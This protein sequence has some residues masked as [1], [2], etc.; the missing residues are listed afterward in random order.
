MT[1]GEPQTLAKDFE[2]R[3]AAS[4]SSDGQSI[5]VGGRDDAGP[6]LFIVPRDGGPARRLTKSE[7]INPVC[8][9]IENLI[10]FSGSQAEAKDW[11]PRNCFPLR[12]VRSDGSSIELPQIKLLRR[13]ERVRFLP[14]GSGVIF[15]Q[16]SQPSQ[17]FWL[18][19][20]ETL[21]SRPLTQLDPVATMR[22]FDVTPDG[23][24]IV[25]DRQREHS[26][27]VV[28]DLAVEGDN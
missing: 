10:L 14:D 3:G 6:G 16:G 24:S 22:A 15:M 13:G 12:A 11:C 17:D 5:A 25:F 28:I 23:K 18:L 4:W 27:I 21:K 26:D 2:V 7:A 1:D 9:P 20:L 19:D 8:S